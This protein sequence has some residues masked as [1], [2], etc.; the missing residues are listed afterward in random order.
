MGAEFPNREVRYPKIFKLSHLGSVWFGEWKNK[1]IKII[2]R[3][4]K[5]KGIKYFYLQL[6]VFDMED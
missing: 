4:K 1:I 6:C 5:W 2:W 3:I